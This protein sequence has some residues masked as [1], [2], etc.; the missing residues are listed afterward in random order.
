VKVVSTPEIRR[1]GRRTS[2]LPLMADSANF[3]TFNE[4]AIN[5]R[6][7]RSNLDNWP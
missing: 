6:N 4:H 1:K 3:A 2:P 7:L 5:V